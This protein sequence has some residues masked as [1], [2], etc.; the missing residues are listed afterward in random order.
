MLGP[1]WCQQ[2]ERDMTLFLQEPWAAGPCRP[3]RGRGRRRVAILATS[4]QRKQMRAANSQLFKDQG[5]E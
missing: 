5:G 3:L 1:A 2:R 4:S